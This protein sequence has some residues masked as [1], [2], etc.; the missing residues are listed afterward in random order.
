MHDAYTALRAEAELLAGA[1]GDI[2]Q[3]VVFHHEIYR[4]SGGNHVFPQVALHGAL[5]ASAFFE[6]TGQL[7]QL[8]RHR[9][10]YNAEEREYRMGLLNGFAEGFKAVNRAVFVDTY[11]NYHFTKRYGR[12]PGA[13]QQLHPDLLAALN[14][15]HDAAA[16][17]ETNGPA[18]R[19]HLFLQA[20]LYEQE[21][22]V[23]PG[24]RAEI[25]RFDCP[26]L[27]RLCLSPIVRFAYFPRG[28]FLLF[29]NFGATEERIRNALRSYTLAERV[30]AP[31]LVRT[32]QTYSTLPPAFF[33][34][35][36]RY[37]ARLRADLL[38]A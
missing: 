27:R 12:A 19:R 24:V 3:R 23:A 7:G 30:G 29:R 4:A 11:T 6:T 21:V 26:I 17:G 8:I 37:A 33:D 20:L 36:A 2:A 34:D 5:W 31:H 35:S 9:Y 25:D 14:Q 38:G 18:E 32:M 10:F 22:T 28:R 16:Q 15:M 1:P 13:E